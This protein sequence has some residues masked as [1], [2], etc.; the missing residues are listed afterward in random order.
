M[1]LRLL[2]SRAPDT[3]CL[4][5]P[6]A[7]SLPAQ[8]LLQ[9]AKRDCRS[10]NRALP[11]LG[12]CA[13]AQVEERLLP[14]LREAP[15]NAQATG[16]APGSSPTSRPSCAAGVL[17]DEAHPGRSSRS[18]LPRRASECHNAGKCYSVP[19]LPLSVGSV[20]AGRYV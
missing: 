14:C 11:E 8:L 10:R 4:G 20:S 1:D 19:V 12:P 13:P 6:S 18:A 3:E 15:E 7:R 5:F 17:P 16:A 9:S 2:L